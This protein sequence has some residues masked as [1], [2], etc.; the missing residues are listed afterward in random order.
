MRTY[1]EGEVVHVEERHLGVILPANEDIRV[2][3]DVCAVKEPS[4]PQAHEAGA[5]AYRDVGP[6]LAPYDASG[7]GSELREGLEELEEAAREIEEEDQGGNGGVGVS[8]L[9]DHHRLGDE[10]EQHRGPVADTFI[11]RWMISLEIN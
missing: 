7:D 2:S 10:V 3:P 4:E 9:L 11:E 6:G 1:V 8:L 5:P